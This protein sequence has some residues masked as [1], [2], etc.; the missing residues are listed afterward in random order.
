[1]QRKITLLSLLLLLT[2][3]LIACGS[4]GIDDQPKSND[5]VE[6]QLTEMFEYTERDPAEVEPPEHVT[7]FKVKVKNLAE[8]EIGIG[9]FDF[10]VF[11]K[12]GKK[13]EAYGYADSLG[14]TID[15]E[16]SVEGTIYFIINKED[17]SKVV[18]TDPELKETMQWDF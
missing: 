2:V 10:E 14:Q 8:Y 18:Y 3:S 5:I 13:V 17:V 12:E 1:M 15:K 11:N 6:I 4:N 9:M 16:E 7:G